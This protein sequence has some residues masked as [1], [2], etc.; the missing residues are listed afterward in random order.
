MGHINL[1]IGDKKRVG[2]LFKGFTLM[3]CGISSEN[4][5]SI[6][7]IESFGNRSYGLNLYFSTK[8]SIISVNNITFNIIGI[9]AE[10]LIL[11]QIK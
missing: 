6:G 7:L 8:K 10:E 1:K 3:Y 5:F 4:V 9:T 2:S 11:E